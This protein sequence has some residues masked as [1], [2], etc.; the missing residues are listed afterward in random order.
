MVQELARRLETDTTTVMVVCDSLEKK[1]L[2]ERRAAALRW[3]RL[4]LNQSRECRVALGLPPSFR[5]LGVLTIGH[6]DER[7][8]N[9][10]EGLELR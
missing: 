9:V 5:V 6:P 1:K 4:T 2:A 10:P 8:L 7:I 3:V